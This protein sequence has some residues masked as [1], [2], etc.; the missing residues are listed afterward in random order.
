VTGKQRSYLKGIAQN[1]DPIINIGKNGITEN[2]IK[3]ADE[4]LEAREIVKFH[5]LNNCDLE[6]K[7]T[8]SELVEILGAEFVSSLGRKFV[9]YRESEKRLITLP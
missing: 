6:P 4:A 5:I 7:A 9:I 8:A 3:Q 2:L 1:I